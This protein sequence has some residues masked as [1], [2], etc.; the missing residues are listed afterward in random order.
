MHASVPHLN[1]NAAVRTVDW[2]AA[3]L[4]LDAEFQV[5]AFAEETRS[6]IPDA[7]MDWVPMHDGRQLNEAVD[8]LR[9]EVPHGGSSLVKLILA[10]RKLSPIPDNVYLITGRAAHSGR[11]RT[12][13]SH[14]EWLA[15]S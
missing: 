5:Y 3:Q 11:K 2:L 12:A 15:A 4:P 10:V 13:G 9:G 14:G 6:L 1:G 7:G 8:A